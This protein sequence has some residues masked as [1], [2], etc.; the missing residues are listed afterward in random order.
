MVEEE[1]ELA[2]NRSLSR[3]ESLSLRFKNKVSQE[4]LT[5]E[6]I[7]G[8]GNTSIEVNLVD[9]STGN[10]VDVGPQASA[11]VEIVLL[12][13]EP[14]DDWPVAEFDENIVR[15]VEGKKPLLAGNIRL[16]LQDGV[17]VVENVKLRH[18][19]S[20]IR[21]SVFRLG[22]RAVQ[23]F[24]GVRIKEA[25]TERFI[26]KD[27]RNKYYKKRETPSLSDEVSRLVNIRKG[28]KMDKR[29]QTGKIFTVE[30]LLIRLLIDPQGL[31]SIAKMGAKKW[32]ATVNNA[33]RCSSDRRVYCYI[34]FEQKIGVVFNLLGQVLGL[35]STSQYASTTMLSENDKASAQK[36]LA[37]AY[38]HWENVTP[39]DDINS[40]K[41]YLTGLS[42]FIDPPN[43]RGRENMTDAIGESS[44]RLSSSSFLSTSSRIDSIRE[45]GVEDFG[46][47]STDDV[48]IIDEAFPPQI[49][50]FDPGNIFSDFDD[51]LKQHENG[52]NGD[53]QIDS[54]GV[55]F[56]DSQVVSVISMRPRRWKKLFC[57]SRLFAV[58]KSVSVNGI[59]ICKKQKVG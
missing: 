24:A 58:K 25:K 50:P 49:S 54:T 8:E 40:L 48:D 20:K 43:Y 15:E 44:S 22:A 9:D 56:V 21:P 7:K 16:K 32:D 52:S 5:G 27:F 38:E 55:T 29:L 45:I 3:I 12:K 30:D 10:I 18:H 53:E 39:F 35:Y 17:G 36:L 31:K 6:E 26:V 47:F 13:G 23:T 46:S 19:T 51:F 28:G 37:S 42:T 11:V 41:Q 59:R 33:R 14:D 2:K 34:N 1:I 4:I 57:V